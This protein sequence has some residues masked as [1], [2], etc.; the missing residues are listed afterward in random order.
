M[1]ART[2]LGWQRGTNPTNH[3]LRVAISTHI[4]REYHSDSGCERSASGWSLRVRAHSFW[5]LWI[6]RA[7]N[8]L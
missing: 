8:T 4:P 2:F 5:G 3:M 1:R 6:G 7:S